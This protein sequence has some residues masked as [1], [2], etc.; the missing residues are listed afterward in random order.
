M[1][2]SSSTWITPMWANPRA[3]PPPSARPMRGGLGTGLGGASIGAGAGG[4]GTTGGLGAV[5]QP[6]NA[7][8]ATAAPATSQRR[9]RGEPGRFDVVFI[10]SVNKQ[11]LIM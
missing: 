10:Y 9:R 4:G 2:L 1:P 3:A 5:W 7:D 6:G 8:S 11:T